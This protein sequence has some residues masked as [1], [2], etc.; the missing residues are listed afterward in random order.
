MT[1]APG[2][3]RWMDQ[4]LRIWMLQLSNNQLSNDLYARV[5]SMTVIN[6]DSPIITVS[7][8]ED[9]IYDHHLIISEDYVGWYSTF[10]KDEKRLERIAN[11]SW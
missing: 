9:G 6:S 3:V 1:E 5:G 7:V 2:D 11:R 4:P 8:I 10:T